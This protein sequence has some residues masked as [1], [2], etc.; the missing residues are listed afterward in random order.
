MFR[1][2][3]CGEVTILGD[4]IEVDGE[5]VEPTRE[6]ALSHG[7]E[8]CEDED[9]S[10]TPAEIASSLDVG[11]YMTNAEKTSAIIKIAEYIKKKEGVEC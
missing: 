5:L 7:Y 8:E 4:V 11:P 9:P 2:I 6:W 1:K 10:S 3:E